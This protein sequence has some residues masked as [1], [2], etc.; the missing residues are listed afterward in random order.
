MNDQITLMPSTVTGSIF[1]PPSKSESHRAIIAASLANGK[2]IIHNIILSEDIKATIRAMESFGVKTVYENHTLMIDSHGQYPQTTEV[3][4]C[5]ESG[6]TLRFIIPLFSL[7]N[8]QTIITGRTS[9]MDRPL[10][11]YENLY[12]KDGFTFKKNNNQL[13]IKAKLKAKRY[14]IP[15][16]ISS[17]FITGLLYA[18]PLLSS[19]S[20]IEIIGDFESKNYVLMTI[21]VL[22]QF[23]VDIKSTKNGFYIK[24]NQM[25]RSR[26]YHI[27]GDYSQAAN[28][29]VAGALSN[30]LSVLNLRHDS[31]QGDKAIVSILKKAHAVIHPTT[32]GYDVK[33][34]HL[35]GNNINIENCPDIGPIVALMCALSK[36]KSIISGASRLRIKESDRIE[37]TVQVLNTLGANI[38]TEGD[39]IHIEG[40]E[41]LKGGIID[42]FNDHR[43]AMMASI[44]SLVSRGPIIIKRAFAI[45]KSY[46]HFY[47]D[48]ESI[49]AIIKR[50]ES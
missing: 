49:G 34:S 20:E 43:I 30:K 4:D 14:Q 42:S 10:N 31:V 7:T 44:A 40:V 5:H 12:L 13:I 24:G 50:E 36:G 35:V 39:D 38:H 41:R 2:S 26:D 48:L 33:R 1:A 29:L 21:D 32:N 37:S 28:F 45:N 15:G 17:Q 23:G 46:P 8:H 22:H 19:D 47:S 6:S 9:L 27:S 16:N 11:V 3:I 18:L 25:Y